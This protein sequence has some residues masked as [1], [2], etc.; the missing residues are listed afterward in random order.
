MRERIRYT[1]HALER[2]AQRG[3]S[4]E[5]VEKCIRSP[6]GLIRGEVVR[7]L[8]DMGVKVLVVV[9]RVED[10]RILVITA[11]KSSKRES[12]RRILPDDY[13]IHRHWNFPRND[14]VKDSRS[15]VRI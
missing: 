8:K 13:Q 9:Y 5:E 3:I 4:R 2:M 12:T 15:T 11:F 7:A 10:E 1:L 14:F 6:D